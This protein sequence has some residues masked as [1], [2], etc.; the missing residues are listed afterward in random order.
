MIDYLILSRQHRMLISSQL[1]FSDHEY[2]CIQYRIQQKDIVL[3][4]LHQNEILPVTEACWT[5]NLEVKR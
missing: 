3:A 4:K 1:K 5:D 2:L